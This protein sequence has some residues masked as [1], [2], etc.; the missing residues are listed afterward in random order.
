VGYLKGMK[1][2]IDLILRETLLNGRSYADVA[3]EYG[4]SR[5]YIRQLCTTDSTEVKTI[6]KDLE[7]E[8]RAIQGSMPLFQKIKIGRIMQ[9]MTQQQVADSI[10]IKQSYLC[11]LENSPRNSSHYN[12]ILDILGL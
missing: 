10:G 9:G 7:T 11:N 5:Q 12:S 3:R 2:N 6:R 1:K 4:C 8:F